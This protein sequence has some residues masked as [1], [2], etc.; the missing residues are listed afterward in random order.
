[1]H[2]LPTWDH[3][4]IVPGPLNVPAMVPVW[5]QSV[6]YISHAIHRHIKLTMPTDLLP[7]VIVN[8]SQ[9]ELH[10]V[11]CMVTIQSLKMEWGTVGIFSL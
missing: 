11:L 9:C 2:F 1:M 7:M 8:L 6:Y 3:N 5:A 10:T 4:I